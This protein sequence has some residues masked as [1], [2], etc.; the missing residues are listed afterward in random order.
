MVGELQWPG[1][2]TA[3]GLR[4]VWYVCEQEEQPWDIARPDPLSVIPVHPIWYV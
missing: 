1:K 2:Q 3:S 4:A